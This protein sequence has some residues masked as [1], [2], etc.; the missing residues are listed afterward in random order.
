MAACC[1]RDACTR[2]CSPSSPSPLH[3]CTWRQLIAARHTCD[4]P[5]IHSC[6]LSCQ[7]AA[8]TPGPVFREPACGFRAPCESRKSSQISRRVRPT[9]SSL[10]CTI[11][12]KAL[13]SMKLQAAYVHTCMT[14]H[15]PAHVESWSNSHSLVKDK[16]FHHQSLPITLMPHVHICIRYVD[17]CT[18]SDCV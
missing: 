16:A 13:P 14:S 15:K 11:A 12:E 18:A 1:R 17:L 9:C 2:S 3:I 8:I 7:K 10:Q 5:W 6:I 4:H